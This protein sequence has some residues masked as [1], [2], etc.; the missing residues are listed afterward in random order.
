MAGGPFIHYLFKFLDKRISISL[1]KDGGLYKK[2]TIICRLR[3]PTASMLRGERTALNL[4]SRLSGIATVTNK[5]ARKTRPFRVKIL[6]TRKTTPLLRELEKYAVKTGG[7]Y[8]HRM[9]LYDMVLIKDNHIRAAGGI[10]KAVILA[11][12]NRPRNIDIE[13]EARNTGEFQAVRSF[14]GIKRVLLDNMTVSQVK[15][16]VKLNKS[17][18]GK[19]VELEVSGGITLANASR[20][21]AAGIDYISA[22]FL[23]HSAPALDM[24]LLI[25]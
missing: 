11:L 14:K 6:D 18:P 20:Y 21:A 25:Q 19:R 23:T 13:I 10:R 9:G 15:K 16:C 4:L 22:G 1:K 3:G 2:G 12:K 8:N 5:M 24:T 17:M 7:G